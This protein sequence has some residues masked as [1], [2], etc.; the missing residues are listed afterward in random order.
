MCIP[1][2]IKVEFH[3]LF[4]IQIY[5]DKF[6]YANLLCERWDSNPQSSEPQSGAL[7]I[8]LQSPCENY[9]NKLY[10]ESCLNH[11]EPSLTH[12]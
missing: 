7:P 4:I 1:Y 3:E 5:K 9:N 10:Q 2:L 6:V 8:Q 12:H 11:Y